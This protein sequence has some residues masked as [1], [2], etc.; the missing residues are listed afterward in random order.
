[1]YLNIIMRVIYIMKY[2]NAVTKA[3]STVVSFQDH[4]HSV[5][6]LDWSGNWSNI[7]GS[8]DVKQSHEIHGN[9]SCLY[10]TQYYHTNSEQ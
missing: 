4:T 6:L 8:D 2:S 5:R 3:K 10:R 1:M 7:P 9:P